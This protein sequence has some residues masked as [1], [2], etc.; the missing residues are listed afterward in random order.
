MSIIYKLP[1]LKDMKDGDKPVEEMEGSSVETDEYFRRVR[2]PVSK[3]QVQALNVG[4]AET[5]TLTGTIKELESRENEND[6][7]NELSI[8]IDSVEVAVKNEFEQLAEDEE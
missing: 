4:D 6:G 7:M 5:V 1:P 2:I 8:A 3:E